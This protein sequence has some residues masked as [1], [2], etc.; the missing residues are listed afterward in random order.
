M[1]DL[2]YD[3]QESIPED[4]RSDAQAKDGKF[5]VSVVPKS[6]LEEFR[7]NNIKI[8][9]ERDSLNGVLSKLVTETGFKYEKPED[10]DAFVNSYKDMVATRTAVENGKLIKDTSLDEAL[11]KRTTE[12]QA[13]HKA[14]V[15]ALVVTRDNFAKQAEGLQNQLNNTLIDQAVTNAAMRSDSGILTSA[16]KAVLREAREFFI[17]Q[18]GKLLA[19]DNEGNTIYGS[20]GTTPM[21]PLEWIKTRLI[22]EAPYL[23]QGSEGGGAGGGGGVSGMSQEEL[24]KLAP[25]ERI[26][27]ARAGSR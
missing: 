9:G 26:R 10:L 16:I 4:I 14:Q 17:M 2:T 13:Q 24:A 8:V 21:N 15:D 5:I 19:K 6:K 18:D 27:L 12:M 7:N 1:P 11:T 3:T 22:K 25:Q 23:F 20:D